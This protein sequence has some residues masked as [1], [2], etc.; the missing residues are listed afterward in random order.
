MTEAQGLEPR[1]IKRF[2]GLEEQVDYL[3]AVQN[4]L[5]PGDFRW[6]PFSAE[7]ETAGWYSANGDKYDLA[8][9]QGVVLEGLPAG[10]KS[11][12]GVTV[13]GSM[14]NVPNCYAANGT[15]YFVRAGEA[16][17]TKQA[18]ATRNFKAKSS[19]RGEKVSPETP[20]AGFIFYDEQ[21]G[22]Y[23]AG[24]QLSGYSLGKLQIDL[25]KAGIPTAAEV[26][27]INM[28]MRPVIWLGV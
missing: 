21:A 10:Y 2:E 5:R 25:S 6:S 1:T 8:S 7:E 27:P 19:L 11:R 3:D 23:F 20:E 17:G 15:G 22:W 4:K 24:Q 13:S 28:Q 16:P 14:I 12:F 18:D 26:R 9:P